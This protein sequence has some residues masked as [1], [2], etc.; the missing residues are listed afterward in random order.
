MTQF[1]AEH[2]YIFA[3]LCLFAIIAVSN[4]GCAWAN[5]W[6]MRKYYETQRKEDAK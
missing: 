4:V 6:A 5:A 1:I 2:P 3:I